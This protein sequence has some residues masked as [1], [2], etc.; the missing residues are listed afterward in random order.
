[1]IRS[2]SYSG[3][4][5]IGIMEALPWIAAIAVYFLLPEYLSLGARIMIFILFTLSL[6]LILGYAGIITLGH[7]VFLGIGAYTAG[8]LS[9]K[10]NVN[11]PF[12]QL[13]AGCLT[14]A[15]FGLVSGAV[16]LRTRNLTLLML[17]LAITAIVYEIGNKASSLTGGADGLPGVQVNPFFG[18][19]E[20]DLWGRTGY[21]YCAI[22]LF[23]IWFVVRRLIYS[24][25]GAMLT[26]IRENT[27]RMH[28]LGA[29]VYQRL[30]IVYTISAGIAGI[31]GVLMTQVTQSVG[32]NVLTFE[33]AGDVLV[34]LILGGVGRIYGAFVGPVVY[35]V[36]QDLLAK[37][38]PEYWSFGVGIL[39]VLV[40]FFARGGILGLVDKIVDRARTP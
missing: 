23:V 9:V 13:I 10:L 21:V 28:A 22:V 24:P 37:Q 7:S 6:D 32:L 8:I 11:D 25:F 34:M 40:V 1:M 2:G 16:I 4:A 12:L 29:P 18:T 20:F 36:A 38:F 33:V 26:G 17:T 3:H 15:L 27:P 35:M 19:F 5:R 39:L 14:S 31:A 30:L